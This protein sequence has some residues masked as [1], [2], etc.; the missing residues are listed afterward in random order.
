MLVIKTF[1][2]DIVSVEEEIFSGLAQKL[3]V[4]GEVGELEILPEHA[5]LLTS[6]A[7]GP[8]WAIKESGEEEAFVL[9]GGMLEVQPDVTIVLAD[10]AFRAKDI[11]EAHAL[12]VQKNVEKRIN[13]REANLDY[14]KAHADLALALAQIRLLKKLRKK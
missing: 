11:D 4:T 8:V 13:Q 5:P 7:P 9:Q 10:S 6:L 3:F 14:A 12:E 1:H 2:L